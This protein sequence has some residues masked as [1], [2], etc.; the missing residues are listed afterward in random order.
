MHKCP[1]CNEDCDCSAGANDVDGCQ[2]ECTPDDGEPGGVTPPPKIEQAP[3]L[4][5]TQE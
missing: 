2:H 1:D 5:L 4:G 3:N